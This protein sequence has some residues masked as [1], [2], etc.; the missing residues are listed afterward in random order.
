MFQFGIYNIV[1]LF[2]NQPI[3]PT[4]LPYYGGWSQIIV[5]LMGTFQIDTEFSLTFEIYAEVTLL[6]IELSRQFPSLD[7]VGSFFQIT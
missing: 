3:S 4:S 2:P 1:T 5:K 7:L 6:I